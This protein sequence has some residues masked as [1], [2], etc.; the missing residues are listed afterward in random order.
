MTTGSLAVPIAN[1]D[2]PTYHRRLLINDGFYWR[3]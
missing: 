1:V 2:D 3:L